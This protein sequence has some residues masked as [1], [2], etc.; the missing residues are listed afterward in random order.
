MPRGSTSASRQPAESERRA[1]LDARRATSRERY[2]TLHAARHD[3]DWGALSA[4]H[5]A[6]LDALLSLTRPDGTILDAACGTGKYWPRILASNRTVVGA[7]Q[8][9]GMLVQARRKHPEVP[10]ATLGL[11]LEESGGDEYL[12]L[13]LRRER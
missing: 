12:H 13:L 5:V 8:S 1:F 3:E 6:A 11:V 7:D 2:D 10:S 9:S 4:S